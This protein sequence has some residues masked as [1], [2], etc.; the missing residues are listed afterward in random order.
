MNWEEYDKENTLIIIHLLSR[1]LHLVGS[2]E[3]HNK[4]SQDSRS[5]GPQ[6]NVRSSTKKCY[7]HELS[8]IAVAF[9]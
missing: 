7:Q 4:N 8:V 3:N 6:K 2:E 9:F 5:A 1:C